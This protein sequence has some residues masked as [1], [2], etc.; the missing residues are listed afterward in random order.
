M[1]D[2][3]RKPVRFIEG[4]QELL[5]IQKSTSGESK[6]VGDYTYP[7]AVGTVHGPVYRRPLDRESGNELFRRYPDGTLDMDAACHVIIDAIHRVRDGGP[8]TGIEMT[9]LS[10]CFPSAFSAVDQ[11]MSSARRAV[12][13]RLSDSERVQLSLKVATHLAEEMQ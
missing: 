1:F 2:L 9:A 4:N 12:S 10:C 3:T 13:L 6:I 8:L 11:G 7:E 5:D